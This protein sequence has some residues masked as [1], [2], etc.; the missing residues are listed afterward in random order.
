ML[1]GTS[2]VFNTADKAKC[3]SCTAV[4]ILKGIVYYNSSNG[5]T[6]TVMHCA[7]RS[8]SSALG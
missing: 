4:Q 7:S 6:E 8:L 3:T 2:S 1:A 5:D